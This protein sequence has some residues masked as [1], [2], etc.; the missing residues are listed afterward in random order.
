MT[1]PTLFFFLMIA[2]FS[3]KDDDTTPGEMI[4]DV[5]P[6]YTPLTTGSYWIYEWAKIDTL[7]NETLMTTRDTISIL[8]DTL[9]NGNTY[10]ILDGTYLGSQSRQFH[11][12]SLGYLVNSNGQVL[13]SESNTDELLHTD[14]IPSGISPFLV[15]EYRM[16]GN[17]TTIDAS[18]GTFDCLNYQ[19]KYIPLDPDYPHGIRYSNVYYADGIGDVESLI[20]Y[21]SSPDNLIRRLV[22]YNIE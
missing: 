10:A 22:E 3:C 18:V 2:F 17:V 15:R 4:D 19:G 1:K 7:G 21:Y 20:F 9:I 13:F 14:S 8:G 12:D 11:R 6:V 5:L 16:E